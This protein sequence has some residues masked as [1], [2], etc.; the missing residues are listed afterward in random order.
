MRKAVF[1]DRDGV[2]NET[3]LVDGSR[4][5]LA[6]SMS[7]ASSMVSLTPSIDFDRPDSL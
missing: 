4:G 3:V 7:F 1:L 2:L 5:H 6:P